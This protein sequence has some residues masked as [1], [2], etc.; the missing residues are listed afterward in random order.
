MSAGPA[1]N[2]G[3]KWASGL[4]PEPCGRNALKT[5]Q[6]FD[7]TDLSRKGAILARS[8]AIAGRSALAARA[9]PIDRTPR[10]LQCY[11]ESQERCHLQS[12]EVNHSLT[13]T[14]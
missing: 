10:R 6:V 3:R 8:R 14:G 9:A 5:T 4:L 7:A 12:Y 11:G 13:L 2:G 1:P